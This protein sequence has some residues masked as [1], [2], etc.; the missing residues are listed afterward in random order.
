MP[1]KKSTK[2]TDPKINKSSELNN[3]IKKMDKES[4]L[5]TAEA[6][7]MKMMDQESEGK[8]F[9]CAQ[10]EQQ[11]QGLKICE[12]IQKTQGCKCGPFTKKNLTGCPFW[13][14]KLNSKAEGKKSAKS[15]SGKA[16][17]Q[18]IMRAYFL[19]TGFATIQTL[20]DLINSH[21]SREKV[22]RKADAKN[23]SVGISILRNSKRVKNPLN[24][25]YS[26]KTKLYYCL[27]FKGMKEKELADVASYDS[28]KKEETKKE[29]TK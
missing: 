4:A 8:S 15:G 3:K 27:D 22:A 25:S 6:G 7:V 1:K 19:E 2:K 11:V 21:P 18:T 5:A 28:A 29:E 20:V 17:Y 12:K 16:S 9:W 14:A 26:K 10:R 24:I 23:T 13:D